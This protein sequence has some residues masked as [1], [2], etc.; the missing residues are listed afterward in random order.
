MAELLSSLNWLAI[1]VATIAYFLLGALW[2][3]PVLFAKKWMELRNI[4][5]EDIDGPNPVIF[6]YSFILQLI[7]VISLALFIAAMGIDSALHGATVGFGAGAGILFT[8]A[9]TTG[10]F[11]QVNMALHFVDNGYHVIGLTLAGLILGAW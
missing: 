2:Y 3:S 1:V 6:F 9:G 5:E 7:G 4:N 11:S 10:I 8:L